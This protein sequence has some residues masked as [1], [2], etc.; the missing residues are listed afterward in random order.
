MAQLRSVQNAEKVSL[1][2]NSVAQCTAVAV[3]AWNLKYAFGNLEKE[4][5]MQARKY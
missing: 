1:R 3:T 2:M 5:L 4:I